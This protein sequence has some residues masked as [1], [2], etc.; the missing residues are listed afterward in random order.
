MSSPSLLL[1]LFVVRG[2]GGDDGLGG[3]EEDV[4][5][6]ALLALAEVVS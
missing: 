6:L 5:G 3:G 1:L 4:P 2:F